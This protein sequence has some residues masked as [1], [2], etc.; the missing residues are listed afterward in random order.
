M[1]IRSSRETRSAFGTTRSTGGWAARFSGSQKALF[2]C[3]L[4][5]TPIPGSPFRA[6]YHSASATL[7]LTTFSRTVTTAAFPG[8]LFECA[9]I[10][11]VLGDR[12]EVTPLHL[13]ECFRCLPDPLA[14]PANHRVFGLPV[15]RREIGRASCRERV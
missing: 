1:A 4:A 8:S 15:S 5:P 2:A 11:G 9:K 10:G 13:A 7:R 12:V 14:G 6:R 3:A